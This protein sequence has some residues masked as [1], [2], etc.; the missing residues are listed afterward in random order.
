MVDG[1]KE[2]FDQDTEKSV[3]ENSQS[4]ADAFREFVKPGVGETN[5]ETQKAADEKAADKLRKALEDATPSNPVS[6]PEAR[7]ADQHHR[8]TIEASEARNSRPEKKGHFGTKILIGLTSLA[9][10]LGIIHIAS[11]RQEEVDRIKDAEWAKTSDGIEKNKVDHKMAE[12]VQN[13][14]VAGKEEAPQYE[15]EG[16]PFEV[17]SKP[18]Q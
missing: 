1:P 13:D 10:S 5:I 7:V 18:K 11:E 15:S 14:N 4:H 6:K 17:D 3:A 16:Q 9:V 12:A 2:I 8:E